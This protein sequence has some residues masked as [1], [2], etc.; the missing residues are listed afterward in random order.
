[1]AWQCRLQIPHANSGAAA[2]PPT[3]MDRTAKTTRDAAVAAAIDRVL[4]A[5]RDC[6][7]AILAA[8]ESA[9]ERLEQARAFRRDLLARTQGRITR[10]HARV[11][12]SL[13]DCEETV[14]EQIAQIRQRESDRVHEGSIAE[15]IKTLAARLTGVVDTDDAHD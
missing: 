4:E 8:E 14:R 1:M 9:A 5:E 2:T 11:A 7:T 3:A 15:S 10:L 12:A 6:E 13:D